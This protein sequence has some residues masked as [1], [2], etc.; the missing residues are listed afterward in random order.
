MPPRPTL[1]GGAASLSGSIAN[2][3]VQR[4][5]TGPST[6]PV[7]NVPQP[8]RNIS[9][10]VGKWVQGVTPSRTSTSLTTTSSPPY[11]PYS[12]DG[13]SADLSSILL[14]GTDTNIQRYREASMR[15]L[16]NCGQTRVWNLLIDVVAQ[17]GRYP[18]SA[19]SLSQF[20]VEGEQHYW[21]HVAIDRFTGQV[22]DKQIEV[23]KE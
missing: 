13:F 19:A 12:Y 2:A 17:T 9:E 16:T 6:G 20:M 5:T 15:A 1:P 7:A 22:I 23:I 8:L 4:T 10:L 11:G 14:S 3:L 21:V 18:Q